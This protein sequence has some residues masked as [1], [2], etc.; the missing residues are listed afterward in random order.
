[1]ARAKR[2]ALA[3]AR[4]THLTDVDIDRLVS[5]L[6]HDS[7]FR[8]RFDVDPVSAARDAG[9]RDLAVVLAAEVHELI[10]LA[11]QIAA[12]A[13]YRAELEADPMST[14]ASAG[15]PAESSEAL[16]HALGAR[17]DVLA[18]VPEVVAHG[19]L[20]Q[21]IRA[22]LVTLLLATSSVA[23]GIRTAAGSQS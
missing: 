16:L 22:R 18:K 9:M 19:Q 15:I 4:A 12:D 1:V 17:E 13:G 21:P 11:E 20:G 2:I 10:A 23:A 14:L 8:E 5:T 6:E 3:Y 7:R